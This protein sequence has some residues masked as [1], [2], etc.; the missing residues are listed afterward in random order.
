MLTGKHAIITG[1]N[2]GIGRAIVEK[3]AQR[4]AD[5]WA[6]ARHETPKFLQTCGELSKRYGRKITPVFFDMTDESAMKDAVKLIKSEKC[7]VDILVNNAGI[8]PENRLFQMA[9]LEECRRVFEVNFFAVMR[10]TQMISKAM[11][12]QKQGAIVNVSSVAALDG[13]PGQ[14]EYVSSKAALVGATRKLAKELGIFGIRVNSVAPGVVNTGVVGS[15]SQDLKERMVSV[16][17]LKRLAEPEEVAEVTAFLA[18]NL[19][20]YM[21]G[22]VVRVDG[23][24]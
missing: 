24:L 2:R 21:T 12:R 20:S 22:Q 4:G 5:I 6:C 19:A 1:A 11:V 8:V 3:F 16:T 7:S 15:M 18:S 17:A 9:S 14:Y 10:L 13:E 23:G